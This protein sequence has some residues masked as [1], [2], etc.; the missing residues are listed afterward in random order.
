MLIGECVVTIFARSSGV[1]AS[2]L[3]RNVK[4]SCPVYGSEGKNN[5]SL[6]YTNT[7]PKE[8]TM[9]PGN[10]LLILINSRL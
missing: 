4:I 5:T 7:W 3:I 10:G 6:K 9:V 8:E 2:F 1:R